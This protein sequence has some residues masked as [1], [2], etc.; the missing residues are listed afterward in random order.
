MLLFAS[1]KVRAA[2]LVALHDDVLLAIATVD[3]R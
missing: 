3:P 2:A 1:R